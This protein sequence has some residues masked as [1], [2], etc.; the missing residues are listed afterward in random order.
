MPRLNLVSLM[1]LKL[2]LHLLALALPI[3]ATVVGKCYVY[4]TCTKTWFQKEHFISP[5]YTVQSLCARP[6]TTI[7]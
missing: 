4:C 6:H 7:V 5:V 1:T 3:H 2:L